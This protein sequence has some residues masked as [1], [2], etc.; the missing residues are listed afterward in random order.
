ML[1]S[2]VNKRR[3]PSLTK[4]STYS[5]MTKIKIKSFYKSHF[6]LQELFSIFSIKSFRLSVPQSKK[7]E[8]IVR[9]VIF[10]KENTSINCSTLTN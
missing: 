6:L 2:K 10:I 5:L 8:E 1:D 7:E 4:E 3:F 9:D